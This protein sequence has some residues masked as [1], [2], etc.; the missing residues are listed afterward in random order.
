METALIYHRWALWYGTEEKQQLQLQ[1]A[2]L[3]YG[4]ALPTADKFPRSH[5]H[6]SK[7]SLPAFRLP[8]YESGGCLEGHFCAHTPIATR[9][10]GVPAQGVVAGITGKQLH[11][12]F[13][14][15]S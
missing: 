4:L 8:M 15:H 6:P 12:W 9:A 10:E 5:S 3:M 13:L 2:G 11:A 14:V 7:Q 1:S